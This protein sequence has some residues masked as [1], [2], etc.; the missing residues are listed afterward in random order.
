MFRVLYKN[1]L[2]IIIYVFEFCRGNMIELSLS[3]KRVLEF[4]GDQ[5]LDVGQQHHVIAIFVG[6]L[7]KLYKGEY[8]F[9]N[10]TSAC[11]WYINEN[12]I[13]EIKAF[14]KR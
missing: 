4:D 8:T 12:D 9:L 5:I 13:A 7:V 6:T 10:G 3:R 14:Q 11:R 1:A 2:P